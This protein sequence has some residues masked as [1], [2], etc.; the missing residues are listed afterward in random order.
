MKPPWR[1][2]VF[3]LCMDIAVIPLRI[4]VL[5]GVLFLQA[6]QRVT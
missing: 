1:D 2:R 5:L 3:Y 4:Y 6:R